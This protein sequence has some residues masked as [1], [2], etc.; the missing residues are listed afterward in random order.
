VLY[1]DS[2]KIAPLL[3]CKAVGQSQQVNQPW[4]LNFEIS[5]PRE[6][7]RAT[8]GDTKPPSGPTLCLASG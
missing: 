5:G 7:R 1:N 2:S 3:P 8:C 6:D 4:L